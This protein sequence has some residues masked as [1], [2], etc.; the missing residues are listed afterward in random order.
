MQRSQGR[1]V[2]RSSIWKKLEAAIAEAKHSK[3]GSSAKM[4]DRAFMEVLL[5]QRC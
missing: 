1:T 5:V 3:A 2:I 4:R